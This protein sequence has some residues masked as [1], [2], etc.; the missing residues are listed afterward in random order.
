MQYKHGFWIV[1]HY[2][3]DTHSDEARHGAARNFKRVVVMWPTPLEMQV[4]VTIALRRL[5]GR[6][7]FE[8]VRTSWVC[9]PLGSLRQMGC[10]M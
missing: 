8:L 1:H 7:K 4:V 10:G 9:G 3:A 6:C 5:L 2:R